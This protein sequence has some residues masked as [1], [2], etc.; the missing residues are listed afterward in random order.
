MVKKAKKLHVRKGDTVEIISGKDKGKR[1]VVLAAAPKE[2]KIVVEGV[3]MLTVHVK[4]RGA[5]EPGGI[6]KKEGAIYA[7]KA[8]LVCKKCKKTTRI[9]HKILDDGSKLR[10]CKNCEE[11]FN[12]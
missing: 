11:T 2:G 12:D 1:G 6:I 4:P 10:V 9:S 3:N 8:M 5:G 7:S